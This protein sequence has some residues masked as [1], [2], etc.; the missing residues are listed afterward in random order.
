MII[1]EAPIDNAWYRAAGAWV[2]ALLGINGLL[3]PLLDYYKQPLVS[4]WA[5]AAAAPIGAG[6]FWF[7][8]KFM[9][10]PEPTRVIT[11]VSIIGVFGIFPLFL[12]L[13]LPITLLTYISI[14]TCINF[15]IYV[16]PC[17]ILAI[18][19]IF[20]SVRNLSK[21]VKESKFIEREFQITED[22]IYLSR[23]PKIVLDARA[24]EPSSLWK[25]T[26]DRLISN[27]V[28]ALPLAY[29]LQKLLF[30]AGGMPAILL[31][32]SVLATPLAIYV[33]GRVTCGAYLWVYI[34]KKL[35]VSHNKPVMFE[36]S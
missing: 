21:R 4:L 36:P 35:E 33:L 8:G 34:V 20:R 31:L 14:T 17:F 28:W 3:W 1:R 27:S 10:K 2:V 29:P 11:F 5:V 26:R 24:S 18:Y 7:I 30:D 9:S 12:S 23:S 22:R 6:I 13:A 25:K 16:L 32:L 19:W 15:V